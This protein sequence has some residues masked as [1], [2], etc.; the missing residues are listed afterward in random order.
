MY[1]VSTKQLATRL[2]GC[3]LASSII[4]LHARGLLLKPVPFPSPAWAPKKSIKLT[5][6]CNAVVDRVFYGQ[7]PLRGS[8]FIPKASKRHINI[9]ETSIPEAGFEEDGETFIF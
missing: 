7:K 3:K 1:Q 4:R 2:Q 6:I 8:N 5:P 9:H